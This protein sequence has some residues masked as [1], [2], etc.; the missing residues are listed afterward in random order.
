LIRTYHG[1]QLV[2]SI[3]GDVLSDSEVWHAY[4]IAGG[5]IERMDIG[6]S[7]AGSEQNPSAAFS[8]HQA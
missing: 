8:H 2:N 1:H 3:G 4:T 7:E 5:L 6:G